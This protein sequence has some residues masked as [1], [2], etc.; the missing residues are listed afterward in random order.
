MRGMRGNLIPWHFMTDSQSWRRPYFKYQVWPGSLSTCPCQLQ[1]YIY[2]Q[3]S[4]KPFHIFWFHFVYATSINCVS[5][6]VFSLTLIHFNLQN[7]HNGRIGLSIHLRRNILN[8]MYGTHKLHVL[9]LWNI[10]IKRANVI[11]SII[12]TQI[13]CAIESEVQQPTILSYLANVRAN[14]DTFNLFTRWPDETYLSNT[15]TK[16]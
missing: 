12:P 7:V 4:C 15:W 6:G 2:S 14:D 5:P 9:F 16:S 13:K 3:I 1:V 10:C 11:I 8:K